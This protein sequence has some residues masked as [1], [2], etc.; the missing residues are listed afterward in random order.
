MHGDLKG[1]LYD[2]LFD[3]LLFTIYS[4]LNY[5]AISFLIAKSSIYFKKLKGS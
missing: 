5:L 3:N 4:R 2:L 1:S